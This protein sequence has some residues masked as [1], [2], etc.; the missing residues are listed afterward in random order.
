METQAQGTKTDDLNQA[1]S[2]QLAKCSN[3]GWIS[4]AIQVKTRGHTC[5][6]GLNPVEPWHTGR[7]ENA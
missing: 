4:S 2:F 1:L 6:R 3:S 7:E 5:D